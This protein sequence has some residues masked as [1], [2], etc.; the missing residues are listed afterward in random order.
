[1]TSCT[2]Q[3]K[4]GG[5]D[6]R[7]T[8]DAIGCAVAVWDAQARLLHGNPAF[9]CRFGR[10]TEH[11]AQPLTQ[12]DFISA[13]ATSGLLVQLPQSGLLDLEGCALVFTDGQVL[14]AESWPMPGGGRVSLFSDITEA[15]RAQR[16][17]E[18][19]RDKATHADQSKSRFLRAANHDLRQP[20]AS[21]KILIY[22]CMEAETE[23]ERQETLHAMDVSVSIIEDLLGALLNIGQLDAGKVE[24]RVQTFQLSTVFE[25]LRIQFG[26]AA[27]DKGLDL[28]IAQSR[29]AIRTDRALLE[30]ILSN[31]VGNAIRYTEFGRV[32]IGCRRHGRSL[33]IEVHD[34][35]IGI[36]PEHQ[37]KVFE[38]FFR[39]AE[40]QP[41]RHSLGLGLNISRRLAEVL[42]HRVS[43]R[44]APGRGSTFA[45]EVP[46]GDVWHSSMGEV[47]INERLG[48]EF[49]G[50]RCLVLEDDR[51]LRDAVIALLQRWGI[52]VQILER[53]DDVPAALAALPQ[54]PDIII[55][56]FRL[57]SGVRGT[58]I[59]HQINDTL[60][61][62]CPAIVITADTGP[63]LIA[64]I[65]A[66]GFPVLIKPVSPPSLRVIMHNILFEPE[67]VPE[68]S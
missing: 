33:R 37:E 31:F 21:L 60:E 50:L 16:G 4:G 41:A 22:S 55:T 64:S 57:R 24:P 20:L 6:D 34:T 7:A 53:F 47:E 2:P 56:D 14:Q 59:V 1:M 10:V 27:R 29:A 63:E 39:V 15:W 44:S 38:E 17:L 26:Q 66:Q 11:V 30:R 68:L 35:G 67:L 52:E 23:Q 43:L 5:A 58:D 12:V 8:L 61:L 46:L 13:L 54:P 40:Q 25:R 36:E 48:G 49:A 32:L 28:R 3:H 42:G 51:M 9:Q 19:A 45:I 62:P 65:R 18:R